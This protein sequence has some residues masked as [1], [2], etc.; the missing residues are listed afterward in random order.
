METII[1]ECK[2]HGL[3]QHNIDKNGKIRCSKCASE[4]TQKRRD[5][6]KILSIEYKGAKYF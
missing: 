6:I 3:C 2:K 4:A 5:K 1:K